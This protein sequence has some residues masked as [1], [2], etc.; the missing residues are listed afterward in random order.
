MTENNAAQPA[1]QEI[2]A[3]MEQAQV[4]ASAWAFFGGPFDNGSGLEQAERER[5]N[6]R[7]LLSK[8]RAEGVQAGDERADLVFDCGKAAG[9]Q[10]VKN[11]QQSPDFQAWI[12]QAYREPENTAYTIYNMEVAYQAGRAALASAPVADESP[13]AKMAD[14]LREK[15]RQE[16]QAYQDRRNQATEWGP[17]PEGTEADNP[18][19]SAP[20]ADEQDRNATISKVVGLCNRIPGATTW[21]A[22]E[23]M[24]DEM[25]R[26]AAPAVA[27][28]RAAVAYLD[29]GAGGYMDV[30]TD[31]TDEQLAALPKGRHMLAIIGTHG[32]NGYTPAS[33]PVAGE[34]QESIEQMAVNRYRPVPD[35][36]FSYKVVA[37]DG[38]RSLYTGTKDSCLRVA[39]KLTEAFLDGAF[40]ASYAAPQ[41]SKPDFADA[42]EGA[43]EDL[44][45]WKRRALEAERDLRAE[46]ETSSRVAGA[47]NAENGPTHMGEPAPQASEAVRDSG[48]ETSMIKPESRAN[49][50]DSVV[51]PPLPSPP[52]HR[53]H[54]MFAGSQMEAYARAA[55]LADRRERCAFSDILVGE[56]AALIPVK[57]VL[58]ATSSGKAMIEYFRAALSAQPSGNPG[59]LAAQPGAQKQEIRYGTNYGHGHVWRRPDGMVTRCG[60]PGICIMCTDDQAHADRVLAQNQGGSDA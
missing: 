40:V 11:E 52:E 55:I 13:M 47:L 49:P 58:A 20:V 48:A 7:A 17:M 42:Y 41:A 60:G 45:I 51:L 16:Q 37:G 44:A 57:D 30:G 15:A 23:F 8:L 59:E 32:V 28:E 31:L 43:R 36:K 19:L 39:A 3:I 21:N 4:F 38:S 10:E 18:T 35:G 9:R 1:D 26:R 6:L 56:L 46:R 2:E 29:L 27:D 34:A 54:A 5:S 24:Y 12:R 25:H 14:A 53:G 50:S 33:A 22:A